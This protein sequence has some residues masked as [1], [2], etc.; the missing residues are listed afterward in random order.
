MRFALALAKSEA[1]PAQCLFGAA[2]G[3][4]AQQFQQ[5]APQTAKPRR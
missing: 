3:L 5:L 2:L 1:T 4:K